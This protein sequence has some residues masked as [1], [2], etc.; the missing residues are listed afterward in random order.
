MTWHTDVPQWDNLITELALLIIYVISVGRL[1]I[2][3]YV[4]SLMWG[5][6]VINGTWMWWHDLFEVKVDS[7]MFVRAIYVTW[8]NNVIKPFNLYYVLVSNL[9]CVHATYVTWRTYVIRTW[10][11][12]DV[13]VASIMFVHANH[14]TCRANVIW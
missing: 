14:V 12:C 8:S 11:L 5:V 3:K 4:L 7:V 13:L 2:N 1:I 6:C 10:N 9:P